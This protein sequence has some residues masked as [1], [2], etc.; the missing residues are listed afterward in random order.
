MF[1]E[2]APSFL[3]MNKIEFLNIFFWQKSVGKNLHVLKRFSWISIWFWSSLFSCKIVCER[4]HSTLPLL[5]L[6]WTKIDLDKIGKFIF[7]HITQTGEEAPN[8][9]LKF[10]CR[11]IRS[12]LFAWI[13]DKCFFEMKQDWVTTKLRRLGLTN[14]IK[15]WNWNPKSEMQHWGPNFVVWFW[16]EYRFSIQSTDLCD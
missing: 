13:N 11:Q 4:R 5:A 6:N 3:A 7:T 2:N 10:T 8:K 9:V 12:N 14:L 15:P 1:F 16:L